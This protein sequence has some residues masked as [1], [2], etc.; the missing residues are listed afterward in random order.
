MV[1]IDEDYIIKKIYDARKNFALRHMFLSIL[2]QDF[3]IE[4]SDEVETAAIDFNRKRILFNPEFAS[5]IIGE[6]ETKRI[7][8]P[9]PVRRIF[10]RETVPPD[11][12]FVFAHEA[13]HQILLGKERAILRGIEPGTPEWKLWNIAQDYVI[14]VMIED[15][16]IATVP[17]GYYYDENAPPGQRW[18]KEG[19]G[20]PVEFCYDP[21]FRGMTTEEVYDYLF[22]QYGLPRNIGGLQGLPTGPGEGPPYPGE[23]RG[24][25]GVT[26]PVDD[27]YGVPRNPEEARRFY[28]ELEDRIVK[29]YNIA[30]VPSGLERIIDEILTPKLDW[31]TLLSRY[32]KYAIMG[33]G[34]E[35][36]TWYPPDK[37]KLGS[38][39]LYLPGMYERVVRAA[40][41]V[42]TSGSITEKEFIDFVSEVQGILN[43]FER[44]E[45]LVVICDDHIETYNRALVDGEMVQYVP[46]RNDYILLRHRG[47]RIPPEFWRQGFGTDYNPVFILIDRLRFR[48]DVLVYFTDLEVGPECFPSVP[49]PYQVIWVCT[50]PPERA[51]KPPFGE[52]IYYER[53]KMKFT[54]F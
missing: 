30:R 21:K 38:L 3:V 34:R 45:L 44:Y 37:K 12:L 53:E 51:Y 11:L 41:A 54:Y 49:P 35:D 9:T 10:K 33:S 43:S 17:R 46:E 16:G 31:R 27:V 52:V 39:G 4:L 22:K 26:V 1:M 28:R 15:L 19:R 20:E 2:I 47:Q 32:M 24:G 48:P 50:Q 36:Y 25:E 18:N 8:G 29:G 6:E 14:N 13:F 23:E 40:V 7:V 5:V 42:D